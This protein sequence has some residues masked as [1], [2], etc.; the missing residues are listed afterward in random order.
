MRV[1]AWCR[2]N[3]VSEQQMYYWLRKFRS[4]EEDAVEDD[5]QWIQLGR[6]DRHDAMRT[7]EDSAVRIH[8]DCAMVTRVR[9]H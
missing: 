4:E 8:I 7:P 6:W 1:P 3:E 5:I 9:P 2:E